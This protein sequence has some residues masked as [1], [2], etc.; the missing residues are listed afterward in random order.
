MFG[1][2]IDWVTTAVLSAALFGMVHVIDSHLISRRMPSLKAYFLLVGSFIFS[3]SVVMAFIFPLPP[4]PM[5]MGVYV[6]N[7]P[8]EFQIVA[9]PGA[10]KP[11]S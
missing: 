6:I 7:L 3:I 10:V 8:P 11:A 1:M 9:L 2:A 4:N 5:L